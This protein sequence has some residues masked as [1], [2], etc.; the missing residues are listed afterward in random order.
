MYTIK[1]KI[2][3]DAGY[4]LKYKNK[5]AFSL[6]DVDSKDVLETKINLEN[7]QK[8]GN[9]VVYPDGYRDYINCT[10]FKEWKT[11]LVNKQFTNNDQI[12]IILNKDD[13]DEDLLLFNKM[14]EWRKWAGIVANKIMDLMNSKNESAS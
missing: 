14:Q 5:I 6:E 1:N 4:I 13:S 10:E 9:F 7:L 8:I 3:A 11:K 2:Y 12:A